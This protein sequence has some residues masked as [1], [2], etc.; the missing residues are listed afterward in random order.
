[1]YKLQN[2]TKAL[3]SFIYLKHN[4]NNNNN[5]NLGW[6][7]NLDYMYHQKGG[8]REKNNDDPEEILMDPMSPTSTS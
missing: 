3:A 5:N 4:K 2:T 1:M 6:Y 8:I 7:Q